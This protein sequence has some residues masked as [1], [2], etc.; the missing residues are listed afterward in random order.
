MYNRTYEGEFNSPLDPTHRRQC[1]G[2]CRMHGE[3]EELIFVVSHFARG[4]SHPPH[5][6]LIAV[7]TIWRCVAESSCDGVSEVTVTKIRLA[8]A[9]QGRRLGKLAYGDF[10]SRPLELNLEKLNPKIP[11]VLI[12]SLVPNR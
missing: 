1:F 9:V 8:V 11:R 10:A 12:R 3:F 4:K 2:E 5:R 7:P 6:T